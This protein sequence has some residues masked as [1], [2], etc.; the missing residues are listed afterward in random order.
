MTRRYTSEVRTARRWCGHNAHRSRRRASSQ[1]GGGSMI[2][3]TPRE[4][5][6]SPWTCSS[7]APRGTKNTIFFDDVRVPAFNLIGGENNGWQVATT[8]LELEH[9]SGGSWRNRLVDKLF[10]RELR[11]KAASQRRSGLRTYWWT[12]TSRRRFLAC[13]DCATTGCATLGS[14]RPSALA[15]SQ[16]VRSPVGAGHAGDTG[17]L[18]ADQ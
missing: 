8:H 2:A 9:G 3:T 13:S 14:R 12:C 6:F 1:P 17:A 11:Q 10:R 18:C 16:A 5:R 15:L 4:S 7:R